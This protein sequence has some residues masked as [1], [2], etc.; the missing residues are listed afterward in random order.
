M[1][2]KP[3]HVRQVVLLRN[4]LPS[5]VPPPEHF[6]SRK[7]RLGV[8]VQWGLLTQLVFAVKVVVL[9]TVLS[10]PNECLLNT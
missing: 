6:R 3:P 9:L 4:L 5:I 1:N 2:V 7:L 10:Q 8:R